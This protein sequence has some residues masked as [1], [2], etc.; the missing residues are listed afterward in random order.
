MKVPL[1]TPGLPTIA[2]A[3]FVV[4]ILVLAPQARAQSLLALAAQQRCAPS[5][6]EADPISQPAALLIPM[7]EA[8]PEHAW[9]AVTDSRIAGSGTGLPDPAATRIGDAEHA[10]PLSGL[11]EA[12]GELYLPTELLRT[13]TDQNTNLDPDSLEQK[14]HCFVFYGITT[15]VERD[16]DPQTNTALAPSKP[17]LVYCGQA[18][19]LPDGILALEFA[20]GRVGQA[21]SVYLFDQRARGLN[22]EDADRTAPAPNA[23]TALVFDQDGRCVRSGDEEALWW[24]SGEPDFRFRPPCRA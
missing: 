8:P 6:P 15:S 16:A 23:T 5:R 9:M 24:P 1:S 11:T 22:S 2:L 21:Y 18:I 19:V 10:Y 4:T 20:D 3:L 17:A 13:Y 14:L 7:R 12:H